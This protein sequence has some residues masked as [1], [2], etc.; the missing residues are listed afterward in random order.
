MLKHITLTWKILPFSTRIITIH[1]DK[2]K[3]LVKPKNDNIITPIVVFYPTF[4]VVIHNIITPIVVLYST[5]RVGI[6]NI[7]THTMVSFT[8][9]SH[10]SW[11]HT[12]HSHTF[13]L[14]IIILAELIHVRDS[15]VLLHLICVYMKPRRA[16]YY[17]AWHHDMCLNVVYDKEESVR[18]LS[19]IPR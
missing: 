7:Q 18:M 14:V 6:H 4:L 11:Y 13:L 8:T 17:C 19:M 1:I 15:R 16:W 3:M 5:F 2:T 9:F 10:L 12:Q